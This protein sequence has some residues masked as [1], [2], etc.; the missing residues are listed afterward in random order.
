MF[1]KGKLLFLAIAAS[2]A[3]TLSR[4]HFHPLTILSTFI[5]LSF[6]LFKNRFQLFLFCLITIVTYVVVFYLTEMENKSSLQEGDY[7]AALE[8]ITI[9]KIDGNFLTGKI[10]NEEGEKLVFSY[11]LDSKKE[12]QLYANLKPGDSCI[13][14]GELQSPKLPTLPNA[15]NYKQYLHDH[16]IH[17]K[18]SV[19]EIERCYAKNGGVMNKLLNLRLFGLSVIE[20]NFPATTVGVVQALIF[21][22]RNLLQEDIEKAYQELGIVH[23]LAI[24]G[25]HVGLL[26]GGV[27]FL[28]LYFGVTHEKAKLFI[29]ICLPIYMIVTGG[30]PSVIRASFMVILYFVLQLFKQKVSPLDVI[31]FTFLC[32]L[33]INPYYLF[34]VGFQLSYVVSFGLLLSSKILHFFSSW[35]AKLT[36]VSLLAQVCAIPLLLYHFY[37]FSLI[38][39]P[40][41]II[42]VPFYSFIILPLAIISTVVVSLPFV[43]FIF[44]KLI[45]SLLELSHQLVLFTSSIPFFTITT[46]KPSSVFLILYVVLLLLLFIIYERTN[47]VKKILWPISL[48]LCLFMFQKFAQMINPYGQVLTIDVGQGDSIFIQQPHNN[49]TFLIDTGGKVSF[50][51][52]AWEESKRSYSIV[53]SVTVP[54]L[55]SIGVTKLN[56]LFLTHGDFDHIGEVLT[57]MEEIRIEQIII[58]IGFNRGELEDRIIKA[59]TKKGIGIK[60]VKDGDQLRYKDITFRVIAPKTLSESKNDDSLVLWTKMGGLSWLFTGDAEINSEQQLIKSYPALKVDV[61]KVGH[62]GSKGSTSELLLDIIKPSY[63]IVSAGLNNRYQHPHPEVV[64]KLLR[65]NIRIL[66]TDLQGAILYQYKGKSGTFLKHPPYDEVKEM[67]K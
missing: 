24:S 19:K 22:E 26:V 41:N 11:I 63:A 2:L 20:N 4:F 1:I 16:H 28:L 21:G 39:L 15:F 61:L 9:P 46:G 32:L 8:I 5:Y 58:P 3:I 18:F 67:K 50:P 43:G 10:K 23:L 65:R 56:G 36:I 34:Q 47:T 48:I 55:K 66:R 33:L 40:M 35:L 49:G 54:Y 27:Y 14:K 62:H 64:D 25:L 45:S 44:V 51:K 60:E 6:L 52:E 7:I 57:L 29:I 12:K 37:E 30:A 38:S 42:F 59:A 13:F 31:S 53:K 17:W